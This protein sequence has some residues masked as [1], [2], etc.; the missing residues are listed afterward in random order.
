MSREVWRQA[1]G[2]IAEHVAAHALP[3]VRIILHGGEPLLAGAD[4]LLAIMAD[5]RQ[6]I[7][8]RCDVRFGMQTNGTLLTEQALRPLARAGLAIGVSLDGVGEQHD[9][10]RRTPAG[11]GTFVAVDRALQLLGSPA[12]RS[13]FS[14]LLCTID[15]LT[16]PVTTYEALLRYRP[17]AI[18]F[19][20]PHANWA[21]PPPHP[22][23]YGDWLIALFDRWC[24]GTGEDV[25][26]RLLGEILHLVLGG[27]SRSEHV[28][29][30]PAAMLVVESDGAVELVDSLKSAYPGAAATGL[31]VGEDPI[32][33]ALTHPGVVARQIGLAALG[34]ECLT[35]PVR[36]VCGGGHY[37][38]RYRPGSGFRHPSVYCADLRTVIRHVGGRVRRHLATSGAR[39]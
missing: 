4:R 16:D 1:A 36:T 39:P 17:P 18:D 33:S 8:D 14:G 21:H 11:R 19:L 5:M 38:H 32:D 15:P 12:Y 7:P 2:R 3:E 35:C 27:A 6:A 24:D 23:R 28:G 29:L 34:D 25:R 30:S 9:R 26:I 10:H 37:A 20:L 13:S 31:T 22:G